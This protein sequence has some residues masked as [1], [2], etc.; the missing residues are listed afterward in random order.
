MKEKKYQ[1]TID[2][3]LQ[4]MG[5]LQKGASRP[6]MDGGQVQYARQLFSVLF[7]AY[8]YS[9]YLNEGIQCMDSLGQVSF[10]QQNCQYE[11]PVAKARLYQLMG[12]NSKAIQWAENYIELPECTDKDRYILHAE[13]ISGVYAY[14]S[15]D[16]SKAIRLL[17]KAVETYQKGGQFLYMPRVISRLSSYYRITGEYEKAV[18]AN[19]KVINSCDANAPTQGAI[20]AY[21]EQ[22]NLYADLDMY[23]QALQQNTIAIHYSLMKDSFGLGDLY[24][25]RAA[26]LSKQQNRD[27]VFHYLALGEQVSARLHSFRGVL[28]NKIEVVKAYLDYPDSLEKAVQLGLSVCPDTVHLPKWA[29]YQLELYLGQALQKTGRT[30]EAISLLEKAACGFASVDMPDMEYEVNRILMKHYQQM[31]MDDD[32]MRCYARSQLFSDSLHTDEKLRAVAAANI[33]FETERKEQENELLSAKVEMQS[34][35]LLYHICISIILLLLFIS[36]VAYLINKRK[37]NRLKME[38]SKQEIQ[39]LIA[40]QQVLSRHNEQLTEQVEQRV[41]SNNMV[42]IS[43]LTGQSLLS[44]EDE[45]TFRQSFAAVHPSYLPKLRQCFPQ[46][47]RNEELLAMLICMNQSTDEIALI[48]GINRSSVNVVR[49]RMRKKMNLSKEDSLDDRLK[50]YLS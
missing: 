19:Q 32:F 27:S 4:T 45:N 28:V 35:Q 11:L 48:M 16:L 17:E 8:M 26:I 46:L 22:A 39:K 13:G 12:N 18:A 37:T 1:E 15:N 21:G 6:A 14:C 34:Q 40:R 23:K 29:Q 33:R 49:S 42:S 20:M 44:K 36:S 3:T 50:R 31:G 10:W 38:R 24:R 30:A 41:I 2:R 25:Y 43:Q 47:T 7:N 5:E 9:S